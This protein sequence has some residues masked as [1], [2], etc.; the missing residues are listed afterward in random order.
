MKYKLI[1]TQTGEEHLCDK[2]TIDGM[3]YYV[4]NSRF[5]NDEYVVRE[6]Y[7][8]TRGFTRILEKYDISKNNFYYHE[9]K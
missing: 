3:D 7:P 1:N 2:V 4:N 5:N 9:K 6:Y 8:T